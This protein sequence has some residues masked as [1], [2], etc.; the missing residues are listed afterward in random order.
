[1]QQL[2]ILDHIPQQIL[3]VEKHT[4]LYEV[5]PKPTLI[6]LTQQRHERPLFVAT[7]LHG[8]EDAGFYALQEMLRNTSSTQQLPRPLILFIGNPQAAR[9]NV[10]HLSNQIDFNRVWDFKGQSWQ[11]KVAREVY[12]YARLRNIFAAIDI[13]NNTGD[14]PFF[15][16]ICQLSWKHLFLASQFSPHIVYFQ[17]PVEILATA[18]S[19]LAPS[20][21]AEC[22]MP[23][24]HEG[25]DQ[26]LF[27]IQKCLR[28][29]EVSQTSMKKEYEY[30]ES[31]ARILVREKFSISVREEGGKWSSDI[32]LEPHLE[33]FNFR[34]MVKGSLIAQ[35]RPE[36]QKPFIVY[37]NDQQ[38]VTDQ[39]L[40]ETDHE[41]RI[42]ANMI[43]SMM[44]SDEKA[45]QQDC[46]GYFMVKG[47]CEI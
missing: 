16:N 41:I 3:H 37:N 46:L 9:Y 32:Q 13:H 25:I 15:T 44:T 18:F 21:T 33:S 45:I 39:F 35:T 30:Y 28:M 1:M 11:H 10:R 17:K 29:K 26:A 34:K 20:V 23:G 14:N 42:K 27:F 24:R 19:N 38:D 7:L 2:N 47:Y 8:N 12:E 36:I 43:P 4:Q 31:V 5:L 6:D 40:E 22:G